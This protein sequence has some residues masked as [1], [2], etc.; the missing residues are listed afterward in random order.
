MRLHPESHLARLSVALQ[1][2]PLPAVRQALRSFH[3]ARRVTL[4]E[5][6]AALLAAGAVDRPGL[7]S[8]RAIAIATR[9]GCAGCGHGYR[10]YQ[11]DLEARIRCPICQ[12]VLSLA[13]DQREEELRPG[14]GPFQEPVYVARRGEPGGLEEGLSFAD[15]ERRAEVE[16]RLFLSV[17][18]AVRRGRDA[19]GGRVVEGVAH[20]RPS[21]AWRHPRAAIVAVGAAAGVAILGAVI[22]ASALLDSPAAVVVGLLGL[23]VV[24]AG[25]A[26][27]AWTERGRNR[28]EDRLLVGAEL[29]IVQIQGGWI[30]RIPPGERGRVDLSGKELSIGSKNGRTTLRLGPANGYY[31]VG[32]IRERVGG[33]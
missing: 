4:Q 31:G 2:A 9:M 11:A 12:G 7:E 6:G 14:A 26:L 30:R 24:S 16:G 5:F 15:L 33:D 1:R 3:R 8:L 20:F 29:G 19:E 10:V 21:L 28:A 22:A 13:S 25:T 27:L 17:V 32:R 18:D 23:L